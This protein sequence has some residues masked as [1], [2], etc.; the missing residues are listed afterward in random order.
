MVILNI[1]NKTFIIYIS[2]LIKLTIMPNFFLLSISY[3]LNNYKNIC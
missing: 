3:F 1:Y 2:V